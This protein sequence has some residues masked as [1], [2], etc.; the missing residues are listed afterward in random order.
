MRLVR[1]QPRRLA[2]NQAADLAGAREAAAA[3]ALS[4]DKTIAQLGA[5]LLEA[6]KRRCEPAIAGLVRDEAGAGLVMAFGLS[7]YA[8]A[9][10]VA[11]VAPALH[12]P[13]MAVTNAI[14]EKI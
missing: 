12:S 14:T 2:G 3:A 10:A 4:G 6:L 13:L 7:S 8:G 9:Q 1:L 5:T 11:G